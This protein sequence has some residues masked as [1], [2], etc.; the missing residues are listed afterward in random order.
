MDTITRDEAETLIRSIER[1]CRGPLKPGAAGAIAE[2]LERGDT[3]KARGV[4]AAAR[5]G[6]GADFNEVILAGPLD[7]EPHAY[8]CPSCGLTGTYTAP[9]LPVAG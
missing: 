8:K 4:D 6:C 1:R 9:L 2:L 5:R 7:G 3:E